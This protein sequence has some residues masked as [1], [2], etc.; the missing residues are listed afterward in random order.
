MRGKGYGKLLMKKSEEHVRLMGFEEMYLFTYDRQTFYE[1][2][3]YI[4]CPAFPRR[5]KPCE[6][7]APDVSKIE[8]YPDY[9]ESVKRLKESLTMKLLNDNNKK[10]ISNK[11]E[12]NDRRI[13]NIQSEPSSKSW[14][15][16]SRSNSIDHF[17]RPNIPPPPLGAPPPPPPPPAPQMMKKGQGLSKIQMLAD[18]IHNHCNIE[19]SEDFSVMIPMRKEL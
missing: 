1:N 7:W 6:N 2:I 19:E 5:G 4:V 15:S 13:N 16:T 12:D 18:Q 14:S 11:L 8:K 9:L 3:G 17:N 10:D